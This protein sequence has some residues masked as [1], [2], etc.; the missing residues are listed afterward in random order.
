MIRAKFRKCRVA[1][2]SCRSSK[3]DYSGVGTISFDQLPLKEGRTRTGMHVWQSGE[4]A[5]TKD[6]IVGSNIAGCLSR[7]LFERASRN[8]PRDL[9]P[10]HCTFH[11]HTPTSVSLT[12]SS[13]ESYTPADLP[14]N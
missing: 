3:T 10:L 7:A 4:L 11:L 13:S 2:P 14:A 5:I 6:P 9:F 8:G 12:C 1:D